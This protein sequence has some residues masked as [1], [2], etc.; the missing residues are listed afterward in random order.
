MLII[1]SRIFVPRY[2]T[3]MTFLQLH[4]S[5]LRKRIGTERIVPSPKEKTELLRIGNTIDHNINDL[6]VIVKPATYRC[7]LNHKRKKADFKHSGYPQI[8]QDI[9]DLVHR[10]A[11]SNTL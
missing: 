9:R 6:L 7:W 8:N 1:V 4:I 3:R 11:L 10:M 2:N 5:I